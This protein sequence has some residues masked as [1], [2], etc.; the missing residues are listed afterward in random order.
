MYL[1]YLGFPLIY[2]QN[3]KR[4]LSIMAASY[5]ETIFKVQATE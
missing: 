3:D 5:L 2:I 4:L 1:K